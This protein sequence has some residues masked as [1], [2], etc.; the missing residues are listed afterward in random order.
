MNFP[1]THL[2][3]WL[4]RAMCAPCPTTVA[5]PD[6]GYVTVFPQEQLYATNILDIECL[7]GLNGDTAEFRFLQ[8][9]PGKPKGLPLN[10][11]HWTLTLQRLHSQPQSYEFQYSVLR[12]QSWPSLAYLPEEIVPC[13]ARICAL[14]ARKPTTASLIP[15]TLGL[16]EAEVFA[17]IEVLRIN[18]HLQANGFSLSDAVQREADAQEAL[19][20]A[21]QPTLLTTTSFITKLWQRLASRN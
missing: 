15:L 19:A 11:L 2:P 8:E 1:A 3:S 7:S 18:G 13:V 21:S 20:N 17:L 14:L 16:P 10:Q 4:Q 6:S 9:I 12:L 5:F